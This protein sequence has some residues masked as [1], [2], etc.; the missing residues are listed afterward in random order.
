MEYMVNHGAVDTIFAD[1]NRKTQEL[2]TMLNELEQGSQAA[3]ASWE[4]QAQ[5]AYRSAKLEW[6][7]AALAMSTML[8]SRAQALNNINMN[9][10]AQDRN[11]ANLFG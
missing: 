2:R 11:A 4:G 10:Q 8:A 3:L 7:S 1:L 5:N 9:Y 6:D